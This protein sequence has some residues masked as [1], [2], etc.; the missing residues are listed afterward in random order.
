MKTKYNIS[1]T[2]KNDLCLGC[3]LCHDECPTKSIR[4]SE[5]NGLYVPIVDNASCINNKGCHKCSTICPGLGIDLSAIS[6]TLFGNDTSKKYNNLVGW[7]IST[8]SG[9]ANN[10]ETRYHGASGGCLTAFLSYL[11]DNG[12]ITAAVVAENDL[13]QPFLNK[14]R[15]I[16]K[17]EDLYKAR[18]SKYCP[19]SFEGIINQIKEE[20]GKVAVVGLPCVIQGFRKAEM[21]DARL[22]EHIFC[23]LG[24][25]CSCGRSFNLTDFVLNE[26]RLNKKELK[27]FQYRDNGCLGNLVAKDA[28]T[29]VDIPFQLYYHPLRSFFIP[30]RCHLCVDHYAELADFSFGD[31][32]WGN[33]KEDQ[34]GVNSIVVRNES[35]L[36]FLQE[37]VKTEYLT[38]NP[39]TEQEL[40]LCQRAAIQKKS[41]VGGYL[42]F[43]K[44]IGCVIPEY[45][46]DFLPYNYCRAIITHLFIKMQMFVGRHH[47]LWWLIKV[48]KR[49]GKIS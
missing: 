34:V 32:H 23:Y 7:Y 40:V 3:G 41:M 13:S 31:I 14:T 22:K 1:Y 30:N 37:A 19:V 45:D 46:I 33:F 39:L 43:M 26:Y 20:R 24:L 42:R 25:Y 16:K 10:Y 18:S 44:Q 35:M 5:K 28:K 2:V 11:L 38:L 48:L 21:H 6:N 27:Y 17:S 29:T 15:L 4:I 47:S 49:K 9:H 8:Y 12:H 36:E